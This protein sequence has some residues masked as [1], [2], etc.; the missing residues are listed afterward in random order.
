MALILLNNSLYDFV[1]EGLVNTQQ[2][3]VTGGTA[4]QTAQNIATAL[5]GRTDA[6]SDHEGRRTN[7]V[8]DNTQA[9]IG[10]V[11]LT[12][13]SA[14]QI[15]HLVR[16]VHNGIHIKQA[17][18][19]LTNHS[20]TLQ[21]HTGIDILLSKLSVIA[22]SV[23]VEL[24]E[25]IVPDFHEAVAITAG[26]AVRLATAEFYTAVIMDL[27]AG[28]AGTGTV[29]P[30][31]ILLAKSGHA[32]LRNTD[33]LGPDIPCLVIVFIDSGIHA[34]RLQT[35]PLG[36]CQELPA[37]LQGL[38]LKVITKGEVTKHLKIGAVTGS[39][40]D[41]FDIAGTDAFL[42]GTDSSSGGLNFT[43]KIRL[44]GSHAGVDQQQRSIVLRNQRKAGQ[45]QVSLA[46]EERQELLTQFVYAIGFMTHGIQPP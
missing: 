13:R 44:H 25:H 38:I 39:F 20:Q 10:L 9:Y 12:V 5:V 22:V 28:T 23:I 2:T 43:G 33:D 35:N 24:G 46:L 30:E 15:C 18:H 7:M 17:V 34:L 6:V 32:L 8:C 31:I 40:T 26:A 29:L 41:I 42:T 27:R 36:A 4:Q 1:Q 3:T 11:A 37:P 14:G 21:T 19:V 16:D 45:T